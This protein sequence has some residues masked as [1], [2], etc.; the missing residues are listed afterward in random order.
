MYGKIFGQSHP[1][2]YACVSVYWVEE[3]ISGVKNTL[4]VTHDWP[5]CCPRF[6]FEQTNLIRPV[7]HYP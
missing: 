5:M 4:N 1:K 6:I 7:Y 3:L 2:F